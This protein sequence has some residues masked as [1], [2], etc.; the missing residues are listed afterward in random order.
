MIK[1]KGHREID[2]LFYEENT[3]KNMCYQRNRKNQRSIRTYPSSA[4]ANT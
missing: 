4:F 2:G 3:Q 1:S